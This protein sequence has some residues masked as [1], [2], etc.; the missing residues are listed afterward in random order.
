MYLETLAKLKRYSAIGLPIPPNAPKHSGPAAARYGMSSKWAKM[1][2]NER[3]KSRVEK[4]LN[5][6]L[7]DVNITFLLDAKIHGKHF[8]W[9]EEHI[10]QADR[11]KEINKDLEQKIPIDPNTPNLSLIHI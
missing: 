4:V 3:T 1:A 6:I 11:I 9:D 7:Y 8:A 2:L 10:L 5:N